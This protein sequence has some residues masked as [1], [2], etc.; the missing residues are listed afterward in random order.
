[1]SCTKIYPPD[2]FLSEV[3]YF[4]KTSF[5]CYTSVKIDACNIVTL[6][7]TPAPL[8]QAGDH[9]KADPRCIV[10]RGTGLSLRP[11]VKPEQGSLIHE[12][13]R[14]LLK[15]EGQEHHRHTLQKLSNMMASNVTDCLLAPPF[16]GEI[17][18]VSIGCGDHPA[19]HTANETHQPV[20]TARRTSTSNRRKNSRGAPAER[21][22][23]RPAARKNTDVQKLVL[24]T[25]ALVAA[26]PEVVVTPLPAGGGSP[27]RRAGAS[28]MGSLSVCEGN[29]AVAIAG[30]GRLIKVRLGAGQARVV[31]SSRALGWTSSV[32][33]LVTGKG[34]G[35]RGGSSAVATFV[36]PGVVYVQSHSLV[37]LRRL[38]LP[39]AGVS[40]EGGV[41]GLGERSR[42]GK[43]ATRGAEMA[44]SMKKG[45]IKRAKAGAGKAVMVLAFFCLYVVVYS[46]ATALLL[47][48]REGLVNAPRHAMQVVRSLA[49]LTQ[50]MVMVLL[51]L[52]REE[53]WRD[54]EGD[55]RGGAKVI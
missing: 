1:M 16:P 53:L 47:E 27:V 43:G 18:L 14:R 17:A 50:R 24:L 21:R 29:G 31:D 36:G 38:L 9:I 19:P 10:S 33:R 28:K 2:C 22:E 49:K 23:K 13:K 51:R 42:G 35:A 34:R 55:K 8:T 12:L 3:D 20:R 25:Q 39:N 32:T 44:L 15:I 41:S 40:L 30:Y 54:D 6:K 4:K 26:G 48:G 7:E 5:H 45:L 37:S 52:G 11:P 46:L